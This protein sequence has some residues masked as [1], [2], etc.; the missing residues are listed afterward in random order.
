MIGPLDV[1]MTAYKSVPLNSQFTSQRTDNTLGFDPP[2]VSPVAF[3][4]H[5]THV[6]ELWCATGK[7]GVTEMLSRHTAKAWTLCESAVVVCEKRPFCTH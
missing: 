2:T 4:L 3:S 1:S 5:D 6:P 7:T